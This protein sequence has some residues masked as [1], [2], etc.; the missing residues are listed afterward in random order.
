MPEDDSIL[1]GDCTGIPPPQVTNGAPLGPLRTNPRDGRVQCAIL[2]DSDLFSLHTITG[3]AS[4][5]V[6]V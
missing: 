2:S 4:A 3:A 1:Q 5:P 6:Q